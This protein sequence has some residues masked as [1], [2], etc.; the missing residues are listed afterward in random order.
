M[1]D[2]SILTLAFSLNA[3]CTYVMSRRAKQ[4]GGVELYN[5]P[6]AWQ[7]KR[8]DQI[9]SLLVYFWSFTAEYRIAAFS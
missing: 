4:N 9:Q 5:L 2:L 6:V 1:S 8:G 3:C 7:V